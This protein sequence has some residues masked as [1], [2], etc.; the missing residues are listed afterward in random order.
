MNHIIQKC[1]VALLVSVLSVGSSITLADAH[2]HDSRH[3][4]S[5]HRSASKYDKSRKHHTAPRYRPAPAFPHYYRPGYRI[6]PPLPRGASRIVVDRSDYYFY[7][8]FFY[9]PQRGGYLI[10]DA[11]VGAIVATLPRLH[12]RLTSRGVLYFVVGNTYYR[13]HPRGY[14]V[15]ENPGVTP[16]R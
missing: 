16:W 2:R 10:V 4:Y 8:G 14:I 9:R 13:Q 7:D 6:G 12:H 11:P 1:L 15:V 5:K 3:S